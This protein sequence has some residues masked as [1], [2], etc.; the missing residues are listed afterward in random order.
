VE[1]MPPRV[2]G[3]EHQC[4]EGNGAEMLQWTGGQHVRPK[5][6]RGNGK[7]SDCNRG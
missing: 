2:A 6:P 7:N 4:R 5:S 1:G 3:R